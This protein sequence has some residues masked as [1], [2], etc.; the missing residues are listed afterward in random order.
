MKAQ[1]NSVKAQKLANES[2]E[3]QTAMMIAQQEKTNAMYQSMYDKN[4]QY[5]KDQDTLNEI[6]K[7]ENQAKW[8]PYVN[9]GTD[10][11]SQYQNAITDSGSW[12]NTQLDPNQIANDPSYKWRL[13]QGL[14]ATNNS[15]AARGSL[16]GGA[17]QK[18]LTDYAQ[19]AASNEYQNAWAR[20]QQVKQNRLNGLGNLVNT[21]M[22]ATGQWTGLNQAS[23]LN[24]VMS[25]IG[26]QYTNQQ[27]ASD[28]SYNDALTGIVANNYNN[29]IKALQS[30]QPKQSMLG[31]FLSGAASGAAAGSAAGPWGALAGGIGGGLYGAFSS[32][33]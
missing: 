17:Q 11:L 26:S 1:D 12:Y 31:G 2:A 7:K 28:S 18:A 9:A 6:A 27:V 23:Q 19:G 13:E 33:G 15:A 8:N 16:L 5:A 3:K 30:A 29:Q 4:M 10:A 14:N 24:N 25:Q 22:S 20:D 32:R 21:G